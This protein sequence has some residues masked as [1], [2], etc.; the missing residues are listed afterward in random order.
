[1][2]TVT[3]RISNIKIDGV[4]DSSLLMQLIEDNGLSIFPQLILTE[5]PDRACSWL[6]NGKIV[7]L[8]DGSSLVIGSPQSFVEFFQSMED[9]NVKWQVASFL[10]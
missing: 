10:R 2:Q 9:Q 5:R 4:L 3:Q 8:V 6:L 1:V 7:I